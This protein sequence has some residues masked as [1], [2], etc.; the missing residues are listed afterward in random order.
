MPSLAHEITPTTWKGQRD[1]AACLDSIKNILGN[2]D[3]A[4]GS[5]NFEYREQPARSEFSVARDTRGR[6]NISISV[7]ELKSEFGQSEDTLRVALSFGL[8]PDG[9]KMN[10]REVKITSNGVLVDDPGLTQDSAEEIYGAMAYQLGII[11]D[12]LKRENSLAGLAIP[13]SY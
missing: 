12:G 2:E 8:S 5:V 6:T 10:V 13:P 1:A 4:E 11:E 3:K 9:N 7:Y